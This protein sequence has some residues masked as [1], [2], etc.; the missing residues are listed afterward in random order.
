MK[1]S[2]LEMVLQI[3]LGLLLFLLPWQTIWIAKEVVIDGVKW[4]Y[5]TQGIYATEILL[6]VSVVLFLV[7]F[8]HRLRSFR[9]EGLHSI[10]QLWS[11]DR[12][13]VLACLAFVVYSFF[14]S[15]WSPIPEVA[16]QHALWALEATLLFFMLIA[17]PL[18]PRGGFLCMIGGAAVQG[19]LA[20]Y[21]FLMQTTFSFKWFGLVYHPVWQAGTSVV[22]SPDIGR[23]SRAY[24]SFPH[25][26]M[27]GG[28]LAIAIILCVV[29]F[30]VQKKQSDQ[31]AYLRVAKFFLPIITAGL[32]FSF[33]RSAWIATGFAF[34]AFIYGMST[35]PARR[36]GLFF[37]GIFVVMFGIL[38]IIF[39]PLL[40]T[41]F[42]PAVSVQESRSVSERTTGYVQAVNLWKQRPWFGVGIG[43]YT[44]AQHLANPTAPVFLLQPVHNVPLLLITELGIVGAAL[45]FVALG[46]AIR[47]ARPIISFVGWLPIIVLGGGALVLL[48]LDHYL[49]SLY[50]GFLVVAMGAGIVFKQGLSTLHPLV[51][52]SQI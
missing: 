40:A 8:T 51:I 23:W 10:R 50:P 16:R 47:L 34:A 42:D 52:D 5:L 44:V 24:G 25:P 21:Q 28:Y 12:F 33:S 13:F 4:E 37:T 7:W 48:S 49:F 9:Q 27:L 22:S 15:L 19:L 38:S 20:I 2:R 3:A 30:L 43:Q 31:G 41:R 26:N 14:S 18:S 32:F 1:H 17:G 39:S 29:L 35:Q 46:S 45:L 36:H 6:W 11:P